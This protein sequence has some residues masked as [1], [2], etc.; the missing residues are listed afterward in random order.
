M[1][2]NKYVALIIFVILCVAMWNVAQ[3]IWHTMV[4]KD[5][6]APA[7]GYDVIR[8]AVASAAVGFVLF[9]LPKKNK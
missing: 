6:W 3:Y 8:P 9:I 5:I 4:S 1:S 7:I 2:K